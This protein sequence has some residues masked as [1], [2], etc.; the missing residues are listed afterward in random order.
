MAWLVRNTPVM[1][2][3]DEQERLANNAVGSYWGEQNTIV[4]APYTGT[5][6]AANAY[7]AGTPTTW[8]G[9]LSHEATHRA[10]ADVYPPYGV[11]PYTPTWEETW[12][13]VQPW[14]EQR[15]PES[16]RR[17]EMMEYLR[18][19]PDEALPWAVGLA[20]GDVSQIPPDLLPWYGNMWDLSKPYEPPPPWPGE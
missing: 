11:V 20:R 13:R 10:L 17:P 6:A 19:Q 15:L 14:F 16:L 5:E 2:A 4:T 8:A 7:L 18:G 3:P 12:Q 1:Y 9:L